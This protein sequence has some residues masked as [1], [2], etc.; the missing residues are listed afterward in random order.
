MTKR[1]FG[2]LAVGTL[3]FGCGSDASEADR[4]ADE[5]TALATPTSTA[6]RAANLPCPNCALFS[7][8]DIENYYGKVYRAA[9]GEFSDWGGGATKMSCTDGTITDVVD[10]GVQPSSLADGINLVKTD[11]PQVDYNIGNVSCVII[12]DTATQ[13]A[14]IDVLIE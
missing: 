14:T 10:L 1:I 9:D 13:N 6:R 7:V 5:P 11:I 4:V 3:M 12:V 2:L 8:T